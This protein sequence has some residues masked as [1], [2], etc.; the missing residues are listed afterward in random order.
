MNLWIFNN[1]D[2]SSPWT[3]RIIHRYYCHHFGRPTLKPLYTVDLGKKRKYSSLT[4]KEC[5]R[6]F[7]GCYRDKMLILLPA[8]LSPCYYFN[9]CP[10]IKTP[11]HY[12]E[13]NVDTWTQ[14]YCV[15]TTYYNIYIKYINALLSIPILHIWVAINCI[16]RTCT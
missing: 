13:T 7:Q 2:Y 15:I 9:C 14:Y 1:S 5:P 6:R 8:N 10:W 12:F 16:I 4:I 11:L 3:I